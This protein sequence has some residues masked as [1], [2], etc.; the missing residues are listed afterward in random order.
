MWS[1]VTH[2]RH[3]HS[4]FCLDEADRMIDLGFEDD[5]RTIFSYFKGQRQTVLFSATMPVKIKGGS[6]A[7]LPWRGNGSAGVL[8]ESLLFDSGDL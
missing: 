6:P 1:L 8:T 5:I 3:L 7:L 4:Y 2:V